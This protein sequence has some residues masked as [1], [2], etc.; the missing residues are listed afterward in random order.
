VVD[1]LLHRR[2]VPDLTQQIEKRAYELYQQRVSSE[3]QQDQDWLRA[4][5]A[6]VGPN[7]RR[8]GIFAGVV[9]GG[10]LVLWFVD[11][12]QAKSIL[13]ELLIVTILIVTLVLWKLPKRQAQRSLGLNVR[14][15]FD[16]END[17]R[18]TLAQI[19]GGV[20]LLAGFYSSVR[21][22]DLQREGQV[23]DRFTKAID[24][25]GAV[26]PGGAVG[27]KGKPKINLE[28]RLG[29]IYALER[30]ANDSQ[31]DEWTIMEVLTAYVRENAARTDEV[32][33]PPGEPSTRLRADIQAIL[34]VIGRRNASPE[35]PPR[36]VKL[37]EHLFVDVFQILDLRNTKL[38][39]ANLYAANLRGANLHGA[40]LHGADLSV[41]RLGGADL[42]ETD[43]RGAKIFEADLAGGDLSVANLRGADL[44]VADLH[45]AKL[46]KADL[47]GADLSWANLNRADLT[48]A[49]LREAQ[50]IKADL[51]GANFHQSKLLK[52][53]VR[54]TDL[55]G[56]GLTQDQLNEARGDGNTVL[57][58]GLSRPASWEK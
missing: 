15:Q 9:L 26:Q 28:V 45:D 24:Q 2:R 31:K 1:W 23:T 30:I 27:E 42:G 40:D 32:M 43:L 52:A 14:N 58:D 6:I 11:E 55:S 16:R 10:F 17:A 36:P 49:D 56:A 20:L 13:P 5:R 41:A 53:D 38:G 44:R 48:G 51:R 34:T 19:I 54:S 25:L 18:K 46:L 21:T 57:P 47:S 33:G 8:Q 37:Q 29:G 7:R 50:L 4:E 3:S 35:F 12:A 39:G 22:L